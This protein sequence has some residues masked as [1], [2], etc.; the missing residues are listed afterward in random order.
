MQIQWLTFTDV[1]LGTVHFCCFMNG[2]CAAVGYPTKA[3][4]GW[5]PGKFTFVS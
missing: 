1:S 4:H 5:K 3:F 2:C